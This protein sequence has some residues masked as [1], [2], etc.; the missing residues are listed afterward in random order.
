MS[1][2]I[3]MCLHMS[4]GVSSWSIS[5]S[6]IQWL[7]HPVIVSMCLL[8]SVGVSSCL[9]FSQLS[10]KAITIRVF[11]AYGLRSFWPSVLALSLIVPKTSAFRLKSSVMFLIKY[12][13]LSIGTTVFI[14]RAPSLIFQVTGTVCPSPFCSFR[15]GG[16]PTPFAS[17]HAKASVIVLLGR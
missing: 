1:V 4:I 14:F 6:V 3:N 8:V 16:G 7:S 17:H 15:R 2:S 9:W 12:E 10:L 13:Y 11:R 5:D